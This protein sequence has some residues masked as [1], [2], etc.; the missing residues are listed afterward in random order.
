MPT[1]VIAFDN[2]LAV[3]LLCLPPGSRLRHLSSPSGGEVD[4]YVEHPDFPAVPE[5]QPAPR[6][7]ARIVGHSPRSGHLRRC[8]LPGSSLAE[9]DWELHYDIEAM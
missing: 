3:R 6:L 4:L 7:L 9:V 2:D 8:L 1:A 5:G